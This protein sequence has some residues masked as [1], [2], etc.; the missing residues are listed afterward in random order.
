MEAPGAEESGMSNLD[1]YQLV[2][3]AAKAGMCDF[4]TARLIPSSQPIQS[5]NYRLAWLRLPW[6][7]S[8]SL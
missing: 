8:L 5:V 3:G 2:L 7:Y 6:F 1:D 4:Q